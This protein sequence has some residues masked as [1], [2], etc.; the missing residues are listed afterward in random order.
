MSSS[1]VAIGTSIGTIIILSH[2]NR[3][4]LVLQNKLGT[5]YIPYA[6]TSLAMSGKYLACGNENGDI[7]ILNACEGYVPVANFNGNGTSCTCIAARGDIV[8]ATFTTGHIKIYRPGIK[9]LAIEIA[10][11]IRC[12]NGILSIYLFIYNYISIFLLL[13]LILL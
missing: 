1:D 6:I 8:I 10:A 7:Y 4:E 13:I 11:H 9:E 3:D 2:N 5:N 12:I